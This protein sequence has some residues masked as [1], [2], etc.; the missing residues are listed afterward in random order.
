VRIASL[1][2]LLLLLPTVGQYSYQQKSSNK[3]W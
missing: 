1:Q 3:P 2:L